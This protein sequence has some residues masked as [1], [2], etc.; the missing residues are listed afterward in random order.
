MQRA[1]QY[2][3]DVSGSSAKTHA[4]A[5]ERIQ[6]HSFGGNAAD[7]RPLLRKLAAVGAARADKENLG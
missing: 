1:V 3:R 5:V 2:A 6:S 7:A 4:D